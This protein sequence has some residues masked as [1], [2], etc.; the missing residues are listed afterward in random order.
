MVREQPVWAPDRS[1]IEQSN[2]EAFRVWL[3]KRHNLALQDYRSLHRWSVDE[4]TQFW[5]SVKDYFGVLSTGRTGPVLLGDRMPEVRWFPATE[6][7]YADQVLRYEGTG[8]AAIVGEGEPGG[9]ASHTVSWSEVRRQISAVAA[10]LRRLGV[11]KG[12]R[13]AGYLPNIPEAVIAFL[14]TASLG[15]VWSSCGQDYSAP[16]AADRIGQLEPVVLVTADGYPYGGKLVDKRESVT[17]LRAALPTVRATIVVERLGLD[18]GD[19][20]DATAWAEASAGRHALTPV[21]VPFGHPLWVLFS[22]GTT[23]RPKGIVHSHGGVLLEHLKQMAF[24]LDLKRG[25]SYFWYTSP[26]WMMWNFQV[27]GLLVGA[28]IVTYDGSPAFPGPDALW[29]LAARHGVK[30]L[31]TSP[32]YLQACEKARVKPAENRDLGRLRILGATGSV[33]PPGTYSWVSQELGDRVALASMT[34]GTDVVSAFAGFVPTEPITAGEL[35]VPCLGVALE[36]WDANGHPVTDEV[37]ELVITR[38]LPSMPLHFWNDP[39]GSRYRDAYFA[40]WPGIWRH[41]DWITVTG[42]G[43]VIVHGRSDSTL[44]RNGVRM[45]SADIYHVVE[46]LP[47]I[48]ES[49]VLGIEYPNGGYWMPLFVVLADGA[50]LDDELRRRIRMA[51]RDGASPKH[52]PDDVIA[53]AGIPHTRTGKKLELPLKRLMQGAALS[54]VVDA[55][56]VDDAAL[57]DVFSSIAAHEQ[58]I[59]GDSKDKGR[60]SGL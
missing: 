5:D 12:D 7:N 56:L 38:P 19:L 34:G 30:V 32:A 4:P 10:Y 18:L 15:A 47:E 49:L 26:S 11:G 2:I 24:H 23:G 45:G 27:A 17:S 39:D 21:A 42:H 16:A 37:G 52:V 3:Q 43:S 44:N 55:Q 1:T 28:T 50:E 59:R 14:A 57:L 6:L 9:P 8:A 60:H 20:P 46:K 51:I 25:D 48:R 13:V 41:G 58:V 54:S 22:S 33:L 40:T 53:V 29:S 35:S 31:G 36:A